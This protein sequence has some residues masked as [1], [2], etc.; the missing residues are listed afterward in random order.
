MNKH[1]KLIKNRI[2]SEYT[3]NFDK[4]DFIILYNCNYQNSLDDYLKE[5]HNDEIDCV[6][7]LTHH[8]IDIQFDADL[9]CAEFRKSIE[10]SIGEYFKLALAE[11]ND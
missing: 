2:I 11:S 3:C 1:V 4:Y 7:D 9:D 8:C 5:C 10:K 6:V